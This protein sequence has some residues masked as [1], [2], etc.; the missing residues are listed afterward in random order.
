MLPVPFGMNAVS[1]E[2][3][4]GG[5]GCSLAGTQT[6]MYGT[7]AQGPT[8]AAWAVAARP[9]AAMALAVAASAGIIN[10]CLAIVNPSD[11]LYALERTLGR[12]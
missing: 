9:T 4:W 3:C 11:D 8:G 12:D 1:P 5:D 10:L 6:P 2:L 7:S